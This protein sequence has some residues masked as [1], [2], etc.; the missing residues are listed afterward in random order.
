MVPVA[1][2]PRGLGSQTFLKKISDDAI[3]EEF[4]LFPTQVFEGKLPPV[5]KRKREK[6]NA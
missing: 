6:A 4:S 5:N 3:I 1:G 2:I